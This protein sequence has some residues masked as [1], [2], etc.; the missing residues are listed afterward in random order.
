ME[1][2]Q[3][4]QSIDDFVVPEIA[5]NTPFV[6]NAILADGDEAS[7]L[8]AVGEEDVPELVEVTVDQ[9][10]AQADTMAKLT[11]QIAVPDELRTPVLTTKESVPVTPSHFIKVEKNI[12]E[13]DRIERYA[14]QDADMAEWR[15][16]K[17]HVMIVSEAG[18][19]IFT[20]YG[21]TDAM[22]TMMCVIPAVSAFAGQLNQTLNAIKVNGTLHV[23]V[24]HGPIYFLIITKT[25]LP[26]LVIRKHTKYY[27]D[28]ITSALTHVFELMLA[29][30]PSYDMRENLTGAAPLISALIRRSIY[31][32]SFTLDALRVCPMPKDPRRD[33]G[34]LI[35]SKRPSTALFAFVTVGRQ[36]VTAGR[37]KNVKALVPGDILILMNTLAVLV[38]S[39]DPNEPVH[40]R[41]PICLPNFNRRGFLYAVTRA[42]V[43]GMLC[44][45]LAT[46]E[47]ACDSLD[48][49][50][51]GM[52][53]ILGDPTRLPLRAALVE[54]V[55]S[56][57]YLADTVIEGK[58]RAPLHFVYVDKVT[59]QMVGPGFGLELIGRD[60]QR[61]AMLRYQ[62]IIARS[63]ETQ[64]GRAMVDSYDDAAVLSWNTK[65]FR[66]LVTYAADTPPAQMV[67]VVKELLD[68][69][70]RKVDKDRR[71]EV[72]ILD[73]PSW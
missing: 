24:K 71:G 13:I 34:D 15:A 65:K 16:H 4:E 29:R 22:N 66:L 27:Y 43:P 73:W 56:P 10:D 44:T 35:T 41:F 67:T 36:L 70:Y 39:Q 61:R 60:E 20:R 58:R 31:D 64:F 18:K 72:F 1:P 51:Q 40:L 12:P 50:L 52:F 48:A 14:G 57:F 25:G 26:E 55:A 11:R 38:Q 21:D 63:E 17:H 6:K 32:I 46:K 3:T 62:R 37:P 49:A 53:V 28:Q 8:F 23:Y 30:R 9:L 19:P 5:F 68:W 69:V 2:R 42:L 7:P 47:E 54:S 33:L 59:S 45:M